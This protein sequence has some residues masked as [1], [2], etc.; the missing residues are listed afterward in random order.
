MRR[1]MVLIALTILALAG[2]P[3]YAEESRI[4]PDITADTTTGNRVATHVAAGGGWST[5]F[6]LINLGTIPATYTLDFYGDSGSPQQFPFKNPKTQQDLGNQS[7]LT[8]NI[9]VGGEV[10]LKAQDKATTTTTGW[11]LID[12]SSTG[13]IGGMAVF[14]YDLTGQQAIVP[15]ENSSTQ[16]FVIAFDNTGGYAT[17]IA[18]VN[19]HANA[20]TVNV[21]V[22]D[23]N[24]VTLQS[25]QIQ[26]QPLEH[27][28]FL[29]SNQYPSLALQAGTAYFS[30]DSAADAVAGLG[31]LADSA[32]AYTTVFA[33]TAQ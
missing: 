24:G 11:A 5:L 28:S 31:I 19:P 4:H 9:P 20:V 6:V 25:G 23:I 1:P 17:G 13:D 29:L 15:I 3:A 21:V 8:G 30:T 27:T 22:R 10:Y 18:L 2:M 26:M 12:P 32:G 14:T 33:L 16:K 7:V